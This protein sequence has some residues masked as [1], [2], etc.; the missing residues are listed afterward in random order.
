MIRKV[1]VLTSSRPR[2]EFRNLLTSQEKY[3]MVLSF[4]EAM[5]ISLMSST[6]RIDISPVL[7][8]VTA[9]IVYFI[10][11]VILATG[12]VH[13][14]YVV[15]QQ[16]FHR[17]SQEKTWGV[18]LCLHRITL[19]IMADQV[20]LRGRVPGVQHQHASRWFRHPLSPSPELR[21]WHR[22]Q[23]CHGVADHTLSASER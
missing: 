6:G 23:P 7:A 4:R 2:S 8:V 18:M 3:I 1:I 22:Q 15:G 9:V 16:L 10:A 5:A 21:A 19:G 13:E 17:I 12:V 20:E 14:H 11:F